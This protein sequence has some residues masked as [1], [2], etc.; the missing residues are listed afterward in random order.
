MIYSSLSMCVTIIGRGGGLGGRGG[1]QSQGSVAAGEK[2][3][4]AKVKLSIK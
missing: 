3:I 2:Q 1:Q 4:T